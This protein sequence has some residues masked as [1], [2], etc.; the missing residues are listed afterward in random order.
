MTD[1][2]QARV[3]VRLRDF[4]RS[5]PMSLLRAREVVMQRFRSSLRMFKLTEQQWRVLRALTSVHEIEV[6]HL[7]HST[8]LLTASLSRILKDLEQRGL[9]ERR[10]DGQDNRRSLISIS[11]AG[12]ALIEAVAP[13]SETIY[14][15]ITAAVGQERLQQ[16]QQ[17]LKELT[18]AVSELPAISLEDIAEDETD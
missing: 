6:T 3:N 10:V 9:I 15:E 4:S 12:I 8:Y 16:L 11:P 17:L 18:I 7:A 1:Q 14:S 2:S 5:L 13:Y